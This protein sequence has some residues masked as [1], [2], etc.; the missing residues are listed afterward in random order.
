[1]ILTLVCASSSLVCPGLR[2]RRYDN[3]GSIL[4]ILIGSALD[5]QLTKKRNAMV[6]IKNIAF[7]PALVDVDQY[8][9]RAQSFEHERVSNGNA[10]ITGTDY[11]NFVFRFCS[12]VLYLLKNNKIL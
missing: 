6:H 7:G 10:Y 3:D 9:V 8:D 1:M 5:G 2:A 11:H 12:H 4:A